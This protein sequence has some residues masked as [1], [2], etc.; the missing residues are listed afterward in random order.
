M[1]WSLQPPLPQ[2]L[3]CPVPRPHAARTPLL[4]DPGT[5]SCPLHP[6]LQDL[7]GLCLLWMLLS[8]SLLFYNIMSAPICRIDGDL[9]IK[10]TVDLFSMIILQQRKAVVVHFFYL[11]HQQL[12]AVLKQFLTIQT[13]KKSFIV[14]SSYKSYRHRK[15]YKL[16]PVVSI[17]FIYCIYIVRSCFGHQ[18]WDGEKKKTF[19]LPQPE[20]QVKI[21]FFINL[22]I[23]LRWIMLSAQHSKA[24]VLLHYH[25]WKKNSN[26]YLPWR[27]CK[28][29]TFL[30]ENAEKK[31]YQLLFFHLSC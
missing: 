3:L 19:T 30:L 11:V 5:L 28:C 31:F 29:L 17:G 26:K 6:K 21:L 22:L 7:L 14:S 25:K 1:A 10:S 15:L 2:S 12:D 4:K 18:D 16:K 24:R 23:L 9:G 27:T 20:L 13:Q 8:V